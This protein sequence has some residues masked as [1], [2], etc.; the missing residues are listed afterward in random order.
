MKQLDIDVS[1]CTNVINLIR[2]LASST[3]GAAVTKFHK[4]CLKKYPSYE[5]FLVTF[6]PVR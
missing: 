2:L 3:T 4:H 1:P 5:L 6:G